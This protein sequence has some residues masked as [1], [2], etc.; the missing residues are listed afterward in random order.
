MKN[1]FAL[2]LC[3]I[4]VLLISLGGI[5]SMA[6]QGRSTPPPVELELSGRDNGRQV[7]L[8]GQVLTLNLEANPSTGYSWAVKG[9]DHKVLRQVGQS[10]WVSQSPELLGAPSTQVLRFAG[11]G[12]GKA[13]LNLEYRRPW[14]KGA[15]PA[16]TFSVHV[17]VAEPSQN[18]LGLETDLAASEEPLAATGDASL[19]AL[20]A[21]FNWCDAG[22]C[23]PVRD[24]GQCGSCWAFGT[25]GAL[26]SAIL[27][28][29]G[30]SKDLSEQYLVSCNMEGWGCDGGWWAHDYHEWKYPPSEPGPGAVYEAEF[31]YTATDSS[32][33]GPY[34]HYETI[35]DWAFIGNDSSVPA[36][37]AIKQAIV[38]Y[39]P[40]AA[41]VCVD[42]A[43][44]GYTDGV[45][46]PR[47]PCNQ[48]N[49]AI[50]LVGWDDTLG[51]WRLRNSWGP[52]WGEDGYMWIAYGKSQ[53]GYSANYVVYGGGTEP[54][55][56][57][58]P[59]PTS[60]PEPGDTIHVS[61]IDMWYTTAGRNYVVY[62]QVAVVDEAGN[63]IGGATVAIRITLPG[64]SAATGSAATA[65]DGTVTFSLKSKETGTY[66]SEVTDVS[67]SSYTYDAGAN[68]ETSESLPVP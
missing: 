6:S 67:H 15:R 37:D 49:H 46:N 58:T 61:A 68:A 13:I 3:L 41:A 60:T 38:D 4:L 51:A 12:R 65:A 47:K 54:T 25:V 18:V 26:E 21:A 40:V 42:S 8:E 22:G 7:Q 45:F 30:A 35:T 63:P 55:P 2:A 33:D 20:P 28:N 62:T 31:P 66:I 52:D 53:V 5:Q 29:D 14:E 64:G 17:Q 59:E 43:F 34:T 24:Q 39:G 1:R 44:Q 36:T 19:T 9:L 16:K 56:T 23:T 27:I 50:V 57:P 10:E 32:C 11:V 48:L